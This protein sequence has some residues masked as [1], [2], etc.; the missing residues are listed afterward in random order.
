MEN[1]SQF[2]HFLLRSFLIFNLLVYMVPLVSPR[3]SRVAFQ[4]MML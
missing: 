2:L 3:F 1:K 4:R